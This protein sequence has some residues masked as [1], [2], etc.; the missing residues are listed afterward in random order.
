MAAVHLHMVE[1]ERD[2][3]CRTE[4]LLAVLAPHHHRVTELVG[5]LVHNAVELGLYH[6]RCAHNHI[7]L[8]ERAAALACN[9]RSQSVVVCSEHGNVLVERNVA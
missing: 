5:V 7:I 9:L 6:G 1:L 4:Q 2:G 8:E 3:Q